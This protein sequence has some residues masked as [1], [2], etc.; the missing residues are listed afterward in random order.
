ML[1]IQGPHFENNW[2]KETFAPP[3]PWLGN[4]VL[5]LELEGRIAWTAKCM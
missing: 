2:P 1:L 5:L 3:Q 4:K